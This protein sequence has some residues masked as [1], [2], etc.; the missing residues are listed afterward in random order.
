MLKM[1]ELPKKLKIAIK[2]KKILSVKK[3][4]NSHLDEPI[5]NIEILCKNIP[6]PDS[7]TLEFIKRTRW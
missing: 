1:P 5:D 4:I 7:H 6:V 3:H 2:H